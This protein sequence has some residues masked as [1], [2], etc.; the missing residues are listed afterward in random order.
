MRDRGSCLISFAALHWRSGFA[1][2]AVALGAQIRRI[3]SNLGDFFLDFS[4]SKQYQVSKGILFMD[5]GPLAEHIN[6][7]VNAA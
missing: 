6:I 4:Q 5:V 2:L 3:L 7:A 1:T